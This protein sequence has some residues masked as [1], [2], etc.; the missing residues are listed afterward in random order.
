M[1]KQVRF[2][3]LVSMFTCTV[4]KQVICINIIFYQVLFMSHLYKLF[5][6]LGQCEKAVKRPV[7][8]V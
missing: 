3:N 8:A 5:H 2:D 6:L 1:I 4:F 7:S